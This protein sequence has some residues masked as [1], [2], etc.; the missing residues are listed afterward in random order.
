MTVT[1]DFLKQG[2]GLSD[3]L[4]SA[5]PLIFVVAG[6]GIVIT[7]RAYRRWFGLVFALGSAW[8][9]INS[10]RDFYV[11]YNALAQ[12][13]RS[14]SYQIAEGVVEHFQPAPC[15]SR[16]SM[17]FD[18]QNVPFSIGESTIKMGYDKTNCGGGTIRAGLYVR[19]WYVDRQT[20]RHIIRLEAR[21]G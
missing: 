4:F 16:G 20:G 14:G 7:Q 8:F 2:P 17:S 1:Y 21:E 18:V 10:F 3:W 13:Y 5:F 9:A 11:T 19:I 12:A 6:L 15:S